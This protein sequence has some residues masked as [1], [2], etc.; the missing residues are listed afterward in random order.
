MGV[1]VD[2]VG[3]IVLHKG[4]DEKDAAS[5][6]EF[7]RAHDFNE[8]EVE[9]FDYVPSNI[10]VCCAGEI[11]QSFFDELKLFIEK[12]G[13]D[14]LPTTYIEVFGDY[15]GGWF[16]EDDKFVFK[17]EIERSVH[18]ASDNQLICELSR[19]GYEAK[20]RCDICEEVS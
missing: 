9:F 13:Y 11:E 15:E 7:F 14:I 2:N 4:I 1:Y 17:N 20:R 19:R 5:I 3:D 18:W 10:H 6:I 8:K 16:Y 12:L